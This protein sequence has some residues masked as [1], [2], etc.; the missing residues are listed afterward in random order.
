MV[1]ERI[2]KNFAFPALDPLELMDGGVGE[3][4]R[5]I[6]IGS[7]MK[8]DI[9][10]NI[11]TLEN[12]RVQ[13]KTIVDCF[14]KHGNLI[15]T[16]LLEPAEEELPIDLEKKEDDEKFKKRECFNIELP[17][18]KEKP[19]VSLGKPL[20][21]EE[22]HFFRFFLDGSLKTYYLGD[23]ILPS[24]SFP[25][26]IGEIAAAC[27]FRIDD[28]T[29]IL[30]PLGFKRRICFLLP[31]KDL[32]P[33]ELQK[34]LEEIPQKFELYS[35]LK[36]EIQYT[37]ERDSKDWR[38]SLR[39]KGL[40]E[41][42]NTEIQLAKEVRNVPEKGWLIIDGSIR[43]ETFLELKNV[44][45]LA[46]SFSRFP[47]FVIDN[48]PLIDIVKLIAGLKEGER[49]LIF[50]QTVTEDDSEKK[51]KD[52]LGFWYV[53]LRSGRWLENP[54][55]GVVKVE[56]KIEENI[57][58]SQTIEIANEISRALL[59]ERTVSPYPTPRWHAHIYPIYTA[60]NYIKN[61]FLSQYYIRGLTI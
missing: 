17:I 45:G 24:F 11:V 14:R 55:Q 60:E 43:K 23:Y 36:V 47:V 61:N 19:Y 8:E 33:N 9:N 22:K 37:E 51:I 13:C 30:P 39:G 4:G 35:G 3:F 27:L 32:L 1:A 26:L 38:S 48:G 21:R 40:S 18:D 25:I 15:K 50:K 46:K 6:N 42:H 10:R 16:P 52:K 57:V 41:M 7:K 59:A 28:G 2:S 12:V 53:R 20:H 34:E 31:P 58:S 54:L 29:L 5:K 49:T 44:I 56:T